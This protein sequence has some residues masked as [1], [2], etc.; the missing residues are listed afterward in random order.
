LNYKV[1]VEV[2]PSLTFAAVRAVVLAGGVA[3]AWKPALDKVWAFLRTN[4]VSNSGL[5]VFYYHHPL[6][7]GEAMNVDFGVEVPK[8]FDD[9]AGIK[10]VATPAGEVAQ[11]VHVGPYNRLGEAHAAIHEWCKANQRT[12][13]A[14]SWEIYGHWNNDP[15][16]LETTIQY[17]L[18]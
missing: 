14:A 1:T 13:A 11:T 12:I 4:Q 6:R 8:S 3:G 5:N 2:A 7:A 18:A 9:E 10:C 15:E 16:K 17:L